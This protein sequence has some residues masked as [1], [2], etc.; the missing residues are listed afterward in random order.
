MYHLYHRRD[1]TYILWTFILGSICHFLYEFSDYNP[2]LALIV[3]VNESVWEHLKL[4][5][6]PVLFLTIAEHSLRRPNPSML[7]ASRFVGV[8]FAMA[9]ITVTIFIFYTFIAGRSIFA[10]GYPDLFYRN[11]PLLYCLQ[12]LIS[13]FPARRSDENF[14][15]LVPFC[16]FILL[17]FVLSSGNRPVSASAIAANA[18]LHRAFRK[19]AHRLT[20]ID[21]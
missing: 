3:P 5:F 21:T 10:S 4:V 19:K 12:Q 11:L 7:F 13:P 20:Q 2:F 14:F 9:A 8:I 15:L 1:F 18:V 6:F 16:T 17:F